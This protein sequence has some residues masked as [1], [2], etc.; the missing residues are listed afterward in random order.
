MTLP[1]QRPLAS[2]AELQ[3]IAHSYQMPERNQ[4]AKSDEMASKWRFL[5]L[6][7]F[8]CIHIHPNR[9]FDSRI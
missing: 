5:P 3:T 1:T 7:L 8:F 6:E 9:H 4:K 2:F